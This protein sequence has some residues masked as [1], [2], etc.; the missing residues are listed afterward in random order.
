M[1]SDSIEVNGMP[2][3][4]AF[5]QQVEYEPIN[6]ELRNQTD[7]LQHQIQETMVQISCMSI[8]GS[9]FITLFD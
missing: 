8:D 3:N 2:Y 9:L 7:E 5:D 4:V 1:A 6:E